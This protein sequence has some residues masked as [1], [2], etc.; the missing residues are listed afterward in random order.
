VVE[1][2]SFVGHGEG[3]GTVGGTVSMRI[4]SS[5]PWSLG[6]FECRAGT[7][8]PPVPAPGKGPLVLETRLDAL[9]AGLDAQFRSEVFVREG[10]GKAT[11]RFEA[12]LV[13]VVVT[14]VGESG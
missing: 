3:D 1:G 7:C 5:P 8:N 13:S 9:P 12:L 4:G 11:L 14:A 6:A 10:S 2:V